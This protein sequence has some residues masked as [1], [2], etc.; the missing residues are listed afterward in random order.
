MWAPLRGARRGQLNVNLMTAAPT[1]DLHA[2]TTASDGTRSP[3]QLVEEAS[4]RGLSVLAVTDH[5]T[6]DGLDEARAAAVE[7]GI[8]LVPGVELSTTVARGEVHLL[9]YFVDPTDQAFVGALRS[10][11]AARRRRIET[12]IALLGA[13]GYDLDRERVMQDAD[14]GSIGR[15]HVARALMRLGVVE[16]V[17]EAFDR[18]LSPGR[19]GWVPRDRF[20]PE[21]AVAMLV[22]NGALP[23]LAHPCSTGAIDETVDRLKPVGL[24]GLEVFYGEYSEDHRRHLH[25]I[26][27]RKGLIPTGGSDYHGPPQREGRG[28]G[29]AEVPA[30]VWDRLAATPEAARLTQAAS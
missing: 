23:V 25:A 8:I 2:H 26:A 9:G 5:D 18:F 24:R 21:Q 17:G 1:I 20:P 27:D 13:L 15:P 4:A 11:A 6:I 29:S 10:L 14:D 28:L 30:W 16:S 22:S 19:P 3:E 7:R 12:M